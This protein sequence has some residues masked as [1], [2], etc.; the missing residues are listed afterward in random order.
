MRC[1]RIGNPKGSHF[2]SRHAGMSRF[3]V[4]G[5]RYEELHAPTAVCVSP[6]PC[7]ALVA[8]GSTA[9]LTLGWIGS[10]VKLEKKLT[11]ISAG[12]C[13]SVFRWYARNFRCRRKLL[14]P[15]VVVS[16]AAVCF[17]FSSLATRRFAL[18]FFMFM[19]A[20]FFSIWI[21]FVSGAGGM[22]RL[23]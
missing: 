22:A 17:Y 8:W 15:S 23:R 19:Y 18:L 4:S 5:D 14:P 1:L 21:P 2:A 3:S 11:I 20:H 6:G 9:M 12:L 10:A 7:L 13:G 16:A